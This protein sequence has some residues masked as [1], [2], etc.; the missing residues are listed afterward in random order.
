M[1]SVVSVRANLQSSVTTTT[2][3]AHSI[4]RP[5]AVAAPSASIMTGLGKELI[6]SKKCPVASLAL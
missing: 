1:P 4:P 2:S 6:I 3:P 5:P